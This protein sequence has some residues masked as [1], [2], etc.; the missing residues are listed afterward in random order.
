MESYGN[1]TDLV[2]YAY[3]FGTGAGR[4]VS[5]NYC[6]RSNM[7]LVGCEG[8]IC[9]RRETYKMQRKYKVEGGCCEAGEECDGMTC[10]EPFCNT[11]KDN[12]ADPN[13][14]PWGWIGVIITFVT[15]AVGRGCASFWKERRLVAEY[16]R[17]AKE[18]RGGGT[19]MVKEKG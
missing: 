4:G 18:R 2:C 10:G 9:Y 3:A 19:E 17:K 11:E 15:L 14:V 16:N 1:R 12:D 7:G 5:R 13:Q 6:D 8:G